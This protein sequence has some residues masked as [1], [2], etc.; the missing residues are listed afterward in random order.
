MLRTV[1]KFL[2]GLVLATGGIAAVIQA[3]WQTLGY[4]AY[5]Q[6]RTARIERS[7]THMAW[8]C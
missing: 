8:Q 6:T 1:G 7:T 2:Q 4:G 5:R 3:G